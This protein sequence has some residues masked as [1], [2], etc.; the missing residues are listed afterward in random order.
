MSRF[1][2]RSEPC[3]NLSAAPALMRLLIAA[4]QRYNGLVD[5]HNP[6]VAALADR[7]QERK[8][9]DGSDLVVTSSAAAGTGATSTTQRPH[10]QPG[11]LRPSSRTRTASMRP[12][13]GRG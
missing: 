6:V 2:A 13:G 8:P 11:T 3:L 7:P 4:S 10:P 5:L 12:V 1:N 9:G